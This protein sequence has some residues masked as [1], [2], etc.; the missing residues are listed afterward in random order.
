MLLAVLDA[1]RA[2]RDA[3]LLARGIVNDEATLRSVV[4]EFA[5]IDLADGIALD[6]SDI[7]IAIIREP[8]DYQGVRL[9]L[10]ADLSSAK[11]K[12]RL[13]LS[14]GDPVTPEP[15]DYPTLLDDPGFRLLGY[16]IAL[17]RLPITQR[18]P[19]VTVP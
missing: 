12:L 16:P 3:D 6:T 14:F 8:A 7:A 13:D 1:R 5:S 2:T 19:A 10:S 15:I 18:S 11:L 17:R 4:S 9:T